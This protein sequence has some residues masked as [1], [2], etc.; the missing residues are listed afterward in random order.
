MAE[1]FG[2]DIRSSSSRVNQLKRRIRGL[3]DSD[4]IMMEILVY[5]VKLNLYLR[6]V[7]IIPSYILQ[8]HQVLLLMFTH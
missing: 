6:S 7:N 1:G 5:F 3:T 8:R 2:K 4:S